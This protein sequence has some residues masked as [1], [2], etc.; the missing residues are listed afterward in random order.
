MLIVCSGCAPEPAS[1]QEIQQTIQ[2]LV[3]QGRAMAIED[4]VV[5]LVASVD[6]AGEP[7]ELRDA[8]AAAIADAVPCAEVTPGDAPEG[9]EVEFADGCTLGGRSLVGGLAVAYARPEGEL[10]ITVTLQE[11]ASGGSTLTGSTR[12]TWG[13]DATQR[14][15]GELR[16]D[17]ANP[18]G[19][20]PGRQIEIQS[21]RI[22]RVR[23]GV[24]QVDGWLRWQTLM[25]NWRAEISGW[26]Q[27]DALLPARGL[28]LVDTPFEHDVIVDHS[29]AGEGRIQVRANGGRTDRV[30]LI[31][32]DGAITDLG[33][34]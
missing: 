20:G 5:A 13:V 24:L 33:E 19:S 32:A 29:D 7:R 2:E 1:T 21:D 6:P 15:V 26:E 28:T 31:A 30:F 4:E 17:A 23:H 11:L 22:Q 12:V 27:A 14:L 25:G 10:V 18:A 34:D 16:L 3:D 9:L 8:V